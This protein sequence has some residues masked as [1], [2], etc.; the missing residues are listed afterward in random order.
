M[1]DEEIPLTR[2]TFSAERATVVAQLGDRYLVTLGDSDTD[3]VVVDM[4]ERQL[5]YGHLRVLSALLDWEPY[6]CTLEGE[7]DV[8]LE[9]LSQFPAVEAKAHG[10]P[11]RD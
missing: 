11:W 5:V 6:E 3:G 7:T 2:P 8:V 4:A 9:T 1:D 10:D